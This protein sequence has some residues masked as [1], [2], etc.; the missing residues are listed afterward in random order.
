MKREFIETKLF[1]N[2]WYDLGLSDLELKEL[3][4]YLASYP[5]A[6]SVITGTGGLRKLRWKLSDKGKRSGIRTIY[7]DFILYEK[8]YLIGVYSKSMKDTLTQNEKKQLKVF[9]KTLLNEL[10]GESNE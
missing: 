9:V 1:T 10:R 5:D 6:G 2:R 4:E 3:Q 8:I 7:V